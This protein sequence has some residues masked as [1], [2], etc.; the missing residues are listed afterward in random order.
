MT[1]GIRAQLKS[2][3]KKEKMVTTRGGSDDRERIEELEAS[4]VALKA[5]VVTHDQVR[6]IE[7]AQRKL[8]DTLNTLSEETRDAMGIIQR[9]F[10]ELKTHVNVLQ[11]AVGRVGSSSGDRGKRAKVPEL[12]RYEGARDAK[13]LENFLFDMEQYFRAVRT[14]SEEDKVAMATMYLA[15]DAKL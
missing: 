12:K 15:G 1:R 5:H 4:V 7:A 6:D 11:M 14:D 9:E 13:D 10:Q 2:A 8:S 3:S